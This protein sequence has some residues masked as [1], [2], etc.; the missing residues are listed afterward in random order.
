[1]LAA[2]CDRALFPRD[3]AAG[4]V[5]LRQQQ[6]ASSSHRTVP[7]LAPLSEPAGDVDVVAHDTV[8]DTFRRYLALLRQ[9]QVWTLV[10]A[11]IVFLI[12]GAVPSQMPLLFSQ[13]RPT[14]YFFS[15]RPLSR[16]GTALGA[17]RGTRSAT[18]NPPITRDS[19]FTRRASR[20]S[21]PRLEMRNCP[22]F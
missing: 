1:M 13:V 17:C 14:Y 21:A 8:L 12:L 2:A 4:L 19:P 7:L 5:R 16:R 9:R 10:V 3:H 15:P 20:S 18:V 11:V 6:A 22:R